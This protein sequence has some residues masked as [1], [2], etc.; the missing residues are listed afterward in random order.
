MARE[1]GPRGI[2]VGHVVV[3]GVIDGEVVGRR[4]PQIREQKGEQGLLDPDALADAFWMLHTQH[5]TA[6]TLELDLR[7]YKEP[8]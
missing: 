2:H 1:F 8:F 4:F 3:D 5:P 6:W 7:P